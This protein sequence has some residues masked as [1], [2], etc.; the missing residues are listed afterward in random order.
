MSA[1]PPGRKKF[2]SMFRWLVAYSQ[3]YKCALCSMLMPPHFDLDHITPLHKGGT[4][5]RQNLQALCAACHSQKTFG[6][7]MVY[8]EEK[9]KTSPFFNTRSRLY[10]GGGSTGSKAAFFESHPPTDAPTNAQGSLRERDLSDRSQTS[11]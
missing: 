4:D 9:G 6:E 3:E 7:M 5:D 8:A 2:T 10:C 11:T 1:K